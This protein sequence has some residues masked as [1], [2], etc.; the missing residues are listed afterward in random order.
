MKRG[1]W[2][3]GASDL[4]TFLAIAER[5]T[6]EGRIAAIRCPTLLTAAEHDPLAAGAASFHAA[7]RCP[8]RLVHFTDAD[9]AGDHC[10]MNNRS[11]VNGV[12]LDWLD[13]T[14]GAPA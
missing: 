3:T 13:E 14:L 2:V 6:L 8:K 10:E 4:R 9:G 1:F 11:T 12:V 5:Y 7:L